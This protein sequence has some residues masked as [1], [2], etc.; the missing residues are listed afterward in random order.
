MTC[1]HLGDLATENGGREIFHGDRKLLNFCN[2]KKEFKIKS[3]LNMFLA[4]LI[5][6]VSHDCP[7]P[8]ALNTQ[9]IT[10][11]T[12]CSV[13]LSQCHSLQKH[14]GSDSRP[15]YAMTALFLLNKQDPMLLQKHNGLRRESQGFSDIST[16]IC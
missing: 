6:A 4:V 12:M 14:L 10:L 5:P 11:C 9:R 13:L 1:D 16:T 7:T 2:N 8:W 3:M 15:L